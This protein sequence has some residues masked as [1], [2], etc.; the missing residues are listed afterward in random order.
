[1]GADYA[2]DMY[3]FGMLLFYMHFPTKISALAPGMVQ[4]PSSCDAELGNLILSLLEVEP[5]KRPLAAAALM[6]PYFRITFVDKLL[7]DGEVVEQKRKLDAV[8]NVIERTR[9]LNRGAFDTIFVHRS[10]V[11]HDV[12]QH[13]MNMPLAKMTH[14]LKVNFVDEPGI[15]EGGLLTEL[16]SVFFEKAFE[17][18]AGLFETCDSDLRSRTRKR[19]A[20]MNLSASSAEDIS[21][22]D[23]ASA[24]IANARTNTHSHTHTN[25]NMFMSSSDIV[26]PMKGATSEQSLRCFRAFGRVLVKCLYE[27]KRTGSRLC[28]SIFKFIT[29]SSPNMRDLQMY[30][31]QTAKSLQWTL[32]TVGVEEFGFHFEEVGAPELGDVNDHNK[33]KFVRMKIDEILVKCRMSQ[34]SAIRDGFTEALKALSQE[35]APFMSLLSHTDWR[36]MLCGSSSVNATQIISALRFSGFPMRSMLPRWLKE[37][38]LSSPEDDLRKFLV[39]TT[40]SPSLVVASSPPP[41]AAGEAASASAFTADADA[42]ADTAAFVTAGGFDRDRAEQEEALTRIEVRFQSRSTSLPVAHTCFFQLDIPNYHDKETLHRKLLYAIHNAN[43]F[44]IV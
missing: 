33:A 39:F 38:L 13:F 28:P 36:I 44:E 3:S 43:T 30:D 15:D 21:P 12:L 2:S 40:G 34:L 8:R 18:A 19:E 27:G 17:E 6:H 41:G 32:A 23:V 10:D 5:R 16:T 26:L 9:S 22:Q 37:I 20:S 35:A 11:V 29:D 14:F 7:Q 1:M 25:T 42:D 24:A 31:A 4:V